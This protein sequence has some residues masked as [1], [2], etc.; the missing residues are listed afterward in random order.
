MNKKNIEKEEKN[1]CY[2][3]ILYICFI[4]GALLIFLGID[5]LNNQEVFFN[6]VFFLLI[7]III[8]IENIEKKLKV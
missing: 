2:D 4:M 1:K 5:F 7:Y 6:G 3:I 8:K